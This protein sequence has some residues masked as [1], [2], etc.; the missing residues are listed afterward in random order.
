MKTLIKKIINITAIVTL[1]SV[2]TPLQAAD[3]EGTWVTEKVKTSGSWTIDDNQITL[4]KLK[5]KGAPDLKIILSPHTEKELNSK[6]AMQGALIVA[7][8][9]DSRGTFTFDLPQGINLNDYKSIG[10]HCEKYTK[11]FGKSAL[12]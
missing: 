11:L 12:R 10:I 7:L 8:V 9:K 3:A 2:S 6:N 1:I 4:T 5:T